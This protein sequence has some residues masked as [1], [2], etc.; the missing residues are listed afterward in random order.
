MPICRE[1]KS[2]VPIPEDAWDYEAG[3]GD[4]IR[5]LRDSLGKYWHAKKVKAEMDASKCP[6]FKVK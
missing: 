4:C 3:I 6:D 5:E 2:F 1:C